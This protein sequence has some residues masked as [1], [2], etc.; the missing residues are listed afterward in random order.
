MRKKSNKI[1]VQLLCANILIITS[2]SKQDAIEE[3][4]ENSIDASAI[5]A[6][7]SSAN[8]ANG[9]MVCGGE[10]CIF[11][12][13]SNENGYLYKMLPDGNEKELIIEDS[14][15]NI[16]V[17]GDY[18]YYQRE[19][20]HCIRAYCISSG[21]SSTLVEDFVEDMVVTSDAIYF[22]SNTIEKIS[23]D[24]KKRIPL[25]SEGEYFYLDICGDNLFYT[26]IGDSIDL[27]TVSNEGENPHLL[28]KEAKGSV[29]IEDRIFYT[30]VED[31]ILYCYNTK[32]QSKE[33]IDTGYNA[34]VWKD[35]IYYIKN[36]NLYCYI[37]DTSTV[38]LQDYFEQIIDDYQLEAYYIVNDYM[39]IIY[40]VYGDDI[41]YEQ[42]IALDLT[43]D[44]TMLK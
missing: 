9:G 29:V 1:F 39:Y 25:I 16:N 22:I 38:V 7:N 6:G 19:N 34:N 21:E 8:H 15:Y 11:F 40:S 20:D 32:D 36:N 31:N 41:G 3:F 35:N 5:L 13:N 26:C 44:S 14:C 37:D 24:G 30:G 28:L 43:D 12:S 10:G 18:I 2:C 27:Y 4:K 17:I 33:L 42:M 23:L